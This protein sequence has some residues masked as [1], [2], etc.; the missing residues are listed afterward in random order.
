MDAG[1]VKFSFRTDWDDHLDLLTS[2]VNTANYADGFL[3]IES[4][5]QSLDKPY[6]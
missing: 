3:N 1:F 6:W 5:F 2:S 4:T